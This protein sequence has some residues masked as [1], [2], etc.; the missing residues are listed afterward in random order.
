MVQSYEPQCLGD[1]AVSKN[2][3]GPSHETATALV[4]HTQPQA[5]LNTGPL[6][7]RLQAVPW[8]W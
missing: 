8:T 1:I 7:A 4:C 3:Y 5:N 2:V 6:S